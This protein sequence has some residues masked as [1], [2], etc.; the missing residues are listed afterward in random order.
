MFDLWGQSASAP[1]PQLELDDIEVPESEIL[2]WEK[3]LLGVYISAHPLES[4]AKDLKGKVT[5]LCGEIHE[6]ASNQDM[7]G[8]EIT[9]AGMVASARRGFTRNNK[10]FVSAVLEGRE[11]AVTAAEAAK[12][13]RL[14]DALYLSARENR[15]VC[16][17]DTCPP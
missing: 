6:M 1:L 12:T 3:E 8:Q 9:I 17:S 2:G 14:I 15:E 4:A 7:A 11:P 10:P 5:G 16:L 13:N